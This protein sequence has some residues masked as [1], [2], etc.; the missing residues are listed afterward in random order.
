MSPT[1]L[2]IL[3]G[4]ALLALVVVPSPAP[5]PAAPGALVETVPVDADSIR[6][7]TTAAPLE[8]FA[9]Y[10]IRA[11]GTFAYGT[12]LRQ[13]DAECTPSPVFG[14]PFGLFGLPGAWFRYGHFFVALNDPF[15]YGVTVPWDVDPTDDATDLYI[16]NRNWEWAPTV[17]TQYGCNELDHTYETFFVPVQTRPVTFRVFDLVYD[18]NSGRLTVEIFKVADPPLP[19]PGVHIQTVLVHARDPVGS[20][21]LP[22]AA[23]RRYLLLAHGTYNYGLF[24]FPHI[25]SFQYIADAE[26]SR[27]DLTLDPNDNVWKRNRFDLG[28]RLDVYVDGSPIEWLGL[29]PSTAEACDMVAHY[30]HAT[31]TGT[32]APV[33]LRIEDGS[34]SDNM[35]TLSVD[36]FELP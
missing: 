34:Y 4:L 5:A 35:G 26:C 28:D 12:G 3:P 7:T 18:D 23:G 32:G 21:S 24:L 29:V 14:L 22:L 20:D 25:F 2:R 9:L 10:R 15:A 36:I 30:Y 27:G 8:A 33:N 13:S 17:P 31:L 19:A 16:D 1:L 11:S 6:G